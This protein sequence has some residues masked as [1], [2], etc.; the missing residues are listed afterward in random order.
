ME[1]EFENFK[2]QKE[3]YDFLYGKLSLEEFVPVAQNNILNMN[4]EDYVFNDLSFKNVISILDDE[5]IRNIDGPNEHFLNIASNAGKIIIMASLM[6]NFGNFFG[7]ENIYEMYLLA[8]NVLNKALTENEKII[9]KFGKKKIAFFLKDSLFVEL[10]EYRLIVIDHNNNN[11]TFN[12]M[13]QGK[14]EQ[15]TKPGSIIIKIFDNFEENQYLKLLKTKTLKNKYNKNFMV[16]YY[17]KK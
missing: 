8:K 11:R 16:F 3:I 7:L 13:L 15:E 12:Q 4:I 1:E 17:E 9:K 2:A 14:V 10:E 5:L 6:Y